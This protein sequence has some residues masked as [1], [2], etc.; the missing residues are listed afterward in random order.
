M[1]ERGA[2]TKEL[3]DSIQK[4]NYNSLP[5]ST[6]QLLPSHP[7]F[8]HASK[9]TCW[10]SKWKYCAGVVGFTICMFTQSPSTPSSRLSV[11]YRDKK[12]IKGGHQSLFS[13]AIS[14]LRT[15]F[16]FLVSTQRSIDR[17]TRTYCKHCDRRRQLKT[18]VKCKANTTHLKESLYSTRRMF[19]SCTIIAMRQ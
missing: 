12:T 18:L 17:Q 1:N 13:I 14:A 3:R 15:F 9:L 7:F 4:K 5:F 11:I 2:S 16:Y 8:R 19:R 10:R 6:R